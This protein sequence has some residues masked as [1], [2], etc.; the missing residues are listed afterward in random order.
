[1]EAFLLIRPKVAR[2]RLTNEKYHLAL[3]AFEMKYFRN[4][5]LT[6]EQV[7]YKDFIYLF[8]KLKA[9]SRFQIVPITLHKR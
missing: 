1:M 6:S 8:Y 7:M 3:L 4:S 2:S 5:V 9:Q